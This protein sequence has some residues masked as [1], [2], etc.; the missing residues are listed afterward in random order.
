MPD[1]NKRNHDGIEW[2]DGEI[3]YRT[4]TDTTVSS[5]NPNRFSNFNKPITLKRILKINLEMAFSIYGPAGRKVFIVCDFP[6]DCQSTYKG[7]SF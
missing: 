1:W 7:I 5:T 3:T 6:L 2:S 4:S